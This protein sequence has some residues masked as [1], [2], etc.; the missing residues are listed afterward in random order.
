M[1]HHHRARAAAAALA[2]F[3]LGPTL[4]ACGGGEAR[5]AADTGDDSPSTSS[6]PSDVPTD[7][8]T[9]DTT[10]DGTDM[11]IR[12]T[13]GDQRF[14]A[15]LDDSPAAD[16]LLAQLPVTV[17]MVDHGDQSYFPGIV[18]LGRLDGDPPERI[19]AL[20]GSVTATV[21]AR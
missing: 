21:E 17:D 18:V 6:R 4:G 8:T 7:D 5:S 10:H 14:T 9:D 19:A 12:I 11:Q 1:T 20:T 15:T 16:D 2:A 13:I 3:A